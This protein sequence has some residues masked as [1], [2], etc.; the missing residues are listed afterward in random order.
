MRFRPFFFDR[1]LNENCVALKREHV[2]P[3]FL[4]LSKLQQ[5]SFEYN[6]RTVNV[7][8]LK[9]YFSRGCFIDRPIG[10]GGT[11]AKKLSLIS[12]GNG[13]SVLCYFMRIYVAQ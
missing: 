3:R 9:S 10:G 12:P 8:V 13:N 2:C 11:A 1:K 4:S 5:P 7:R 6:F